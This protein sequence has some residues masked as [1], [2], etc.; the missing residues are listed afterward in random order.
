[1]RLTSVFSSSDPLGRGLLAC[2]S[3]LAT[4]AAFSAFLNLLYLAP[5]LYMLQVYDRVLPT[6]GGATLLLVSAILAIA[7]L[8]LTCLDWLRTRLMIRCAA[9]LDLALAGPVIR[10]VLSQRGLSRIER[11]RLVRDFD[12]FKSVLSGGVA[13]AAFDAPWMIIYVLAAFLLHPALGLLCVAGAMVMFALAYLNERMSGEALTEANSV[14]A[15]AYARQDQVSASAAEVRAL[16]MVEAMVSQQLVGRATVAKLQTKANF[17][18]GYIAATI[19][20]LRLALQSTALG[21][22]AWLA[23]KGQISAGSL[24]AASFLLARAVGPV[25]QIVGS[26]KGI[27]QARDAYS[28]LRR[29]FAAAQEGASRT[30]L[31]APLGGLTLEKVSV[32]PPHGDRLS[33]I[34]V[35]LVVQPGEMI[36]VVGP[37]G[38]GKSTLIRTLAG[39]VEPVRGFVR[40]DGAS[41]LDWDPERLASYVGYMPQDVVLFSGSIKDNIARF[42]PSLAHGS[43]A[44]D[45]KVI[46]AAKAAGAHELILRLAQGYDTLMGLGGVGLSGGQLQR[47]ALA[48]A[49]YG[50]PRILILDEPNSH[51]DSEGEAILCETLGR[52][53][54]QGVTIVLAAHRGAVL[55]NADKI[56]VLAAGQ[57]QSFGDLAQTTA[58]MSAAAGRV[59]QPSFQRTA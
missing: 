39:A 3:H 49:L 41:R 35:D 50:S 2:R 7:L 16:G 5:T 6:N 4:V 12:T 36:G 14:A 15:A 31:P 29:L 30:Q 9:R 42:E 20:L 43:P 33:L 46:E 11:T 37:S 19:K 28:S 18:A 45:A 38:S 56:L 21:L 47:I 40:F 23:I 52:L 22:A 25:E 54:S 10:Q 27:V 1:M 13:L 32:L 58:M 44:I 17:S 51:L 34:D 26:W 57:V 24:M 53:R 55:A 8:T 48:R 59:S